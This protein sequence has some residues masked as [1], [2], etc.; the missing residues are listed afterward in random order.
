MDTGKKD[1]ARRDA[2]DALTPLREAMGRLFEESF[3]GP[4]WFETWG[5]TRAP[6]VNIY[7]T[8]ADYIVEVA[9]P[10]FHP[11]EIQITT[12][13]DRLTIHANHVQKATAEH[14][15][16]LRREY[17]HNE[18]TRVITLPSHLEADKIEAT[19]EHGMLT[20]RAPKGEAAKPK[21]IT[22]RTR[23]PALPGAR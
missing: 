18:F 23:E 3:V 12:L 7:E 1:V 15:E 11:D 4:D 8:E 13:G 6:Y 16:T 2:R 19:Y 20:L 14:R 9:A 22:L 10:G 5:F 21:T 17:A